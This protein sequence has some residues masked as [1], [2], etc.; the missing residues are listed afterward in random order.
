M[1]SPYLQTDSKYMEALCIRGFRT[2]NKSLGR[3]VSGSS[4]WSVMFGRSWE[5]IT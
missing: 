2:V 3:L 1:W 5:N 4:M